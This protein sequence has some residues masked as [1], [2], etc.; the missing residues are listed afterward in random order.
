MKEN[1]ASIHL[2]VSDLPVNLYLV[3]TAGRYATL[4]AVVG[5]SESSRKQGLDLTDESSFMESLSQIGTVRSPLRSRIRLIGVGRASLKAFFYKVRAKDESGVDKHEDRMIAQRSHLLP[6]HENHQDNEEDER[7]VPIVMAEFTMIRDAPISST[8]SESQ[9]GNK[10]ARS[11]HCSPVHAL[12]KISGVMNRVICLHDDRRRLVKGLQAAKLRL[13]KA[14]VF[15]DHDGIGQATVRNEDDQALI[16]E[17]LAKY[18]HAD[19]PPLDTSS[20]AL[21]KNYGLNYYSTFSSIPQLTRV[22]LETLEPYYSAEVRRSE[23]HE[24]EITSFVAFRALDGFCSAQELAAALQCTNTIER[25]HAAYDLMRQHK[26]LLVNMAEFTSQD[27]QDCGEECT[28]L[29]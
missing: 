28:D 11:V 26:T 7:E 1:V 25:F 2:F 14:N 16:E 29:W 13:E 22:A 10:R 5:I 27:L 24:M 12:A 19:V 18:N 4:A 9:L 15:E 23:E 8:A 20:L 17:F 6:E 3:R 21:M